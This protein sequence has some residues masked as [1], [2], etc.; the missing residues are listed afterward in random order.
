MKKLNRA[1]KKKLIRIVLALLLA[2]PVLL[3]ETEGLVAFLLF[4]PSY[5]VIAYETLLK[6]AKGI[7]R[8]Q[9]FDENFLMAVATLGAIA[10]GEYSEAVAVMLFYQTGELFESIAVSRSR[11]SIAQLMDI[12]PEYANVDDGQGGYTQIDP[13]SIRVGMELVVLAGERVPVDGTVVA[14]CSSLDCSALTGESMPKELA[15]GDGIISG[16]INLS[17]P[18]R[19]R[20]EKEY[21]QSTVARVLEL[22]ENASS[23]KSRSENFIS[24]FA[25]VYTPAVCIAALLLALVPPVYSIIAGEAAAW[26]KWLYRALSF[27]VISCPC[28]LVISVP[29]SFFAAIGGAGRAGVLVKGSNYMEALSKVDSI[30]MDKTGTLTKGEF[31]LVEIKPEGISKE[32][33]L[34]L[35]AHA[36]CMSLHPISRSIV[37]AYGKNCRTELVENVRELAGKGLL[38]RVSG[39]EVALGNM[40]LMREMDISVQETDSAGTVIYAVVDGCY[41]GYL[42]IADTLKESSKAAVEKLRRMGIDE[43]MLLTGDN[44]VVGT[45]IAKE[46]GIDRVFCSLLPQHKLEIVERE[47]ENKG[48]GL[49]AFVGDGINDAPV[50]ARADVGIA[51]GALGSDAAIEAADVVLM[52]DDPGKIAKAIAISKKCM[53]IVYQNIFFAIGVKL[54]CLLLSVLGLAGMWLAIFADVGVMVLA[55]LN[56]VRAMSVKKL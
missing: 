26:G 50:L 48:S 10:L 47:L 24:R 36:E 25:A 15:E 31:S 27:L 55:V 2:L 12:R 52:D 49:M 41:A 1:Q 32:E 45:S 23:R 46:L 21:G 9:A 54:L 40:T 30:A 14:G 22:V 33:L 35:A 13:E 16:C 56:A 11:K 18:L 20:A 34:E 28:A 38:A 53:K 43:L 6:A 42:R 19:I 39:R 8:G 3:L 29:L 37:S 17:S 51:M 4:M 5:L 44:E 7:G